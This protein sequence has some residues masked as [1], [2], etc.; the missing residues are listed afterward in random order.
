MGWGSVVRISYARMY[1]GWWPH[2]CVSRYAIASRRSSGLV[3]LNRLDA[4]SSG[5]LLLIAPI[6]RG[7]SSLKLREGLAGARSAHPASK[8]ADKSKM[9]VLMCMNHRQDS[10]AWQRKAWKTGAITQISESA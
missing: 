2:F 1:G 5:V 4:A 10:L 9:D 6:M 7:I 8:I 3:T